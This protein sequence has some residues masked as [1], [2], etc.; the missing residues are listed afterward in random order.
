MR[1]SRSRRWTAPSRCCRWPGWRTHDYL[2]HGIT[3]LFAAFNIADGTAISQ[4]HPRPP[5]T[6][7][8]PPACTCTWSATL[9][10]PQHRRD[11]DVARPPLRFLFHFTPTNSSWMNQSPARVR[12]ADRQ[13]DPPR[14]PHLRAGPRERHQG[15]GQHLKHHPPAVHL[16]QD[17]RR[18]LELFGHLPRQAQHKPSGRQARIIS[19][20]SGAAH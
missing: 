14:R 1:R 9:R 6:R 11:Q 18:D 3:S 20:I 7:R 16:D 12:P 13:A 4:L 8:C 2:R 10:H 17:L 15:V 5:S 19:E